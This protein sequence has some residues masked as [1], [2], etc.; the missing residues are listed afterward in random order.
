MERRGDNKYVA[1]IRINYIINIM[2]RHKDGE[3]CPPNPYDTS[4]LHNYICHAY[5]YSVHI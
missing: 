4:V 5:D 3:P 1:I 2:L